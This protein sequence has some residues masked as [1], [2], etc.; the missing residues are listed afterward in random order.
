MT[1]T[2]PNHRRGNH[3]DE[4]DSPS[5]D[6]D[7]I[8]T[9]Y[10]RLLEELDPDRLHGILLHRRKSRDER[11]Y[12]M[13]VAQSS[14]KF[15]GPAL[16][17]RTVTVDLE[18]DKVVTGDN[19][20]WV[21]R[22]TDV[23]DNLTR[24]V[25]RSTTDVARD[26]NE[27][28][29]LMLSAIGESIGELLEEDVSEDDFEPEDGW[30]VDYG[31]GQGEPPEVW[32][33]VDR[34]E[35]ANLETERFS[36]LDFESKTPWER[37]ANRPASELLGNYGVETLED[38]RLII[39][40][41]DYP[42]A[43]D[44]ELPETLAVSSANGSDERAHYYY[45]LPEDIDKHGLHD[46]YESWVLKPDWGDVWIAGEYVVGPGSRLD[47]GGS[48]DVVSDE[49]IR[50]LEATEIMDLIPRSVNDDS[51]D[52]VD[53]DADEETDV[54]IVDHTDEDDDEEELVE[55]WE[56]GE[57]IAPDDAV[58]VQ[59]DGQPVYVDGGVLDDE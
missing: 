21:P 40:D 15:G 49:P 51:D 1:D 38:G 45:A 43:L 56:T 53:D 27:S 19:G 35:E 25:G 8:E 50:E 20:L 30:G 14:R 46:Y 18:A 54:E 39:L 24:L 37:Y 10:E 2:K 26:D 13:V 9:V 48:Y 12:Y 59:R 41:V 28:E 22:E 58:L 4:W 57:M 55:C 32:D 3:W 11:V 44:V 36:R 33:L 42:E 6:D 47:D 17:L 29:P 5:N 52:E 34:L 16:D 31:N 23:L 7:E